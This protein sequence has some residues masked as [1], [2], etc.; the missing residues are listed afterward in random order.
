MSQTQF[1]RLV[2]A[3]DAVLAAYAARWVRVDCTPDEE[4]TLRELNDEREALRALA[5]QPDEVPECTD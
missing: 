2:A 5:G 3:V 1:E 4:R